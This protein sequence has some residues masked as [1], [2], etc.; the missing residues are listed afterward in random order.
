MLPVM[1]GKKG[2]FTR[3]AKESSIYY[4]HRLIFE[5]NMAKPGVLNGN[6]LHE[7]ALEACKFV[8]PDFLLNIAPI[9]KVISLRHLQGISILLIREDA[10]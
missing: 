1:E 3:V 2:N 6:P 10:N 8:K 9:M 5:G 7:D 4:N